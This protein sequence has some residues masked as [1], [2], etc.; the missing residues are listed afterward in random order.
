MGHPSDDVR[1]D[2]ILAV[3]RRISVENEGRQRFNGLIID[4]GQ[5][6]HNF[7]EPMGNDS[8]LNLYP[9][10]RRLDSAP[11]GQASLPTF[12][13]FRR[14]AA[15]VHWR[16]SLRRR[17][18]WQTSVDYIYHRAILALL[19]VGFSCR[20]KLNRRFRLEEQWGWLC[21]NNII[22]V[23]ETANNSTAVVLSTFVS[24]YCAAACPSSSSLL[25]ICSF[26]FKFLQLPSVCCAIT[27]SML[28]DYLSR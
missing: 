12:Q 11:A 24:Q 25:S 8:L 16:G 18:G 10:Q 28:T 1:K 26:S 19:T 20:G 2:R 22:H 5:I 27:S 17:M 7:Q 6:T 23:T 14:G 9:K 21:R 4:K 13:G 3:H 15:S